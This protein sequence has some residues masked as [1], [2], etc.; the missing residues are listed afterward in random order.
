MD[1]KTLSDST[2]YIVCMDH[3]K[4]SYH[5]K[6]KK[7]LEDYGKGITVDDFCK[8]VLAA[9]HNL[10]LRAIRVESGYKNGHWWVVVKI[11]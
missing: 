7:K 6:K 1:S 9:L 3:R 4:K 2:G 11:F 8:E 5:F 10:N